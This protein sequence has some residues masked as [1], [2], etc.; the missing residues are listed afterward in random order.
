MHR[1][2][3]LRRRVVAIAGAL[4]FIIAS[5]GV[6]AVPAAAAVANPVL[7]DYDAAI[8]GPPDA[9]KVRPVN[10]SATIAALQRANVNTYAYMIY[11]NGAAN[12]Y[13]VGQ[14][15]PC[16]GTINAHRVSQAQWNQLPAFADAAEAVGIDVWVYLVPPSESFRGTKAVPVP[17][18]VSTY[19]P[20]YWD[21]H[22]WGTEIAELA[23]THPSIVAIAMDDFGGN[24][25]EGG[26]N[27]SFKFSGSYITT[28][29]NAVRA[30]SPGMEFHVIL[31]YTQFWGMNSIAAAYRKV[32]DGYIFPYNWSNDT[33]VEP[34]NTSNSSRAAAQGEL[35]SSMTKCWSGNGCLQLGVPG[36][37]AT[38][39]GWYGSVEQ[40]VTVNSSASYSMRFRVADS[41]IGAQPVGYH[42]LQVLIDGQVAWTQDVVN[43]RAWQYV[44]LDLTS[45]LQGKTSARLTLR[46][47]EKTGVANFPIKAW[48]DSFSST[49]FTITNPGFETSLSGWTLLES[50]A[51][52]D[53]SWVPNLSYIL[54]PYA[55]RLGSEGAANPAYRTS[56]AYISAV[57]TVGLNMTRAGRANGTLV[58][59]LNLTGADNGG[60]DPL[61]LDAVGDLYGSYP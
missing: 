30:I 52:F 48:F 51:L 10:I 49:G 59:C 25:V 46:I 4:V 16:D 8:L 21:Y 20:Y 38:T 22:R 2:K 12:A 37:T 27:Y 44:E 29:M 5:T 18:R 40:T 41:W 36:Q 6:A 26:S 17:D 13:C 14:P 60:G 33:A 58:Y 43:Y 54:M 50:R 28:M 15:T 57:T 56:A 35:T 23:V 7:G 53:E 19:A 3:L 55:S 42:E 45:R 61:A 34:G 24:T 31:Y 39:T 11:G 47:H 32:V 9:N 1:W